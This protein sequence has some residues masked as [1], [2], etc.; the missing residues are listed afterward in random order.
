MGG[1]PESPTFT[2][3]PLFGVELGRVPDNLST[4]A[5]HNI[6]PVSENDSSLAYPFLY[7]TY[8]SDNLFRG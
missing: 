4:V 3:A 2:S 1:L 8:P 5:E 7:L 6:D